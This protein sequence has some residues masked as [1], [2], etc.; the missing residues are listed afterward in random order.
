[1]NTFVTICT[2]A[3]VVVGAS[4]IEGATV[5]FDAGEPAG[6]GHWISYKFDGSRA[7]VYDDFS[8]PTPATLTGI[9]FWSVEA[10]DW[11]GRLEYYIHTDQGG[12]PTI[13][14]LVHGSGTGVARESTGRVFPGGSEYT[15]SFNIEE[16]LE[17]SGN[18]T[19][20]LG[21]YLGSTDSSGALFWDITQ[22]DFGANAVRATFSQGVPTW[23]QLSAP[24]AQN[25]AFQL[26]GVPILEPS[27]LSLL[28]LSGL[29]MLRRRRR[30]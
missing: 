17:L 4:Q 10:D 30:R 2:P 24:N 25:V 27:T 22:S 21:L 8:L 3:A 20:W 1:M 6:T 7:P 14:P 13:A 12:V 18:S 26:S 29:A 19:Y 9:T 23:Q 11:D 15:Y 28:A 5:L 16:P